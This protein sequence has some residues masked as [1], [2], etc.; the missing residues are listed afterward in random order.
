[1][2]KRVSAAIA[3]GAAILAVGL[4]ATPAFAATSLTVKV[5]G[6]GNYTATTTKTV[7]SDN[8]VNVTC[9]ST[10]SAAASKASGSLP[11]ATTKGNAP[12]KVG[13]AAKLA[14]NNC[15]GPLGKVTTKVE[16]LPYAVNANSVTNSKGETAATIS[17]TKIAVS[18]TDC[19]F[20]VT[21]SAPGFY[22]NSNHTLT[23][24]SKSP[25]KGIVKAQL[26][27][28]KVNGCL[29]VVKN[30]DHPTYTATYTVSP[31]VQ[32]KST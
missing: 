21:G 17:G 31:K 9:K 28:S 29:G 4:S 2:L 24:T 27:V 26:T 20:L 13:T 25:V 3:G 12:V 32:I 16:A 7:L 14:F 6:G 22:T 23:M 11:N 19:S 18:T 8:G 5:T 15:T 30:G 10:K 1:M